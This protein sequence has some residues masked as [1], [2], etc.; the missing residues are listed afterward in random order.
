MI[1]TFFRIMKSLFQNPNEL[2][3]NAFLSGRKEIKPLFKPL[4]KVVVG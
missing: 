4:H 1:F 2:S 3:L